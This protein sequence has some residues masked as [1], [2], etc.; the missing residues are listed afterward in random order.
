MSENVFELAIIAFIIAGICVA[1]WKGGA[2]NP[3]GTG[4]LR[5]TINRFDTEQKRI[6]QEVK[7][8]DRRVTEKLKQQ[9]AGFGELRDGLKSL[10]RDIDE[11]K[12]SAA[13]RH[14]TLTHIGGQVDRLYDHI[15][16]KGMDA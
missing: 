5:R 15:V 11:L 4:S 10:D 7:A 3:E 9:D 1:I 13:A 6:D 2:A 14:Q 16:R 12:N 8:M